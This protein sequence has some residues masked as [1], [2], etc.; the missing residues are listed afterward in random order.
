MFNNK[1]N[2]FKTKVKIISIIVVVFAIIILGLL[3]SMS[4][5]ASLT[6][7]LIQKDMQ[8]LNEEAKTLIAKFMGKV[9]LDTDETEEDVL[10]ELLD[11]KLSLKVKLFEG[12]NVF[13][14]EYIINDEELGNTYFTREDLK[15][16]LEATK[17]A[18][19][20]E[21]NTITYKVKRKV[22]ERLVVT[23]EY[24]PEETETLEDGTVVVVKPEVPEK[25]E[26]QAVSEDDESA[27]TY[28]KRT[29]GA[30]SAQYETKNISWKEVYSMYVLVSLAKSDGWEKDT[31]INKENDEEDEYILGNRLDKD[32]LD[33][34]IDMFVYDY[35][36]LYDAARTDKTDLDWDDLENVTYMYSEEKFETDT[37]RGTIYVKVPTSSIAFI[38]NSYYYYEVRTDKNRQII[39]YYE[40]FDA[41]KFFAT[42]YSKT[43]EFKWDWYI[44][45]LSQLPG[46]DDLCKKY[47]EYYESY[48][49]GEEFFKEYYSSNSNELPD[50]GVTIGSGV[51]NVDGDGNI[52]LPKPPDYI[53]DTD[54]L[55]A[56]L[57]LMRKDNLTQEQMEDV[58]NWWLTTA[59][60]YSS[61][62]MWYPEIKVTAKAFLDAQ[63]ANGISALGMLA[64]ASHESGFGTSQIA[65]DKY[66]FF[67]YGAFDASPYASALTC[68]GIYNGIVTIVTK[69]TNGY[70]KG[71]YK[72]DTFWKFRHNVVD[73][74]PV[75]QYCT[76]VWE[77][78]GVRCVTF[79]E[80]LMKYCDAKG[81]DLGYDVETG[82]NHTT[83]EQVQNLIST[84]AKLQVG[85]PYKYR[86]TRL[87]TGTDC[88][89][90]VKQI[91]QTFASATNA[92]A[93]VSAYAMVLPTSYKDQLLYGFD[94]GSL[95]DIQPADVIY[96]RS[97]GIIYRSAVYI[98]NNMV[99][100]PSSS[101]KKVVMEEVS[102]ES[103]NIY[104]IK[105][106]VSETKK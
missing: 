96:Y 93:D 102:I 4:G 57:T 105:R 71:P 12:K 65:R 19:K 28:P 3:D 106:F 13:K 37:E 94:V 39:G 36:Y 89:N 87:A 104:K 14:T 27:V 85:K 81:Y 54:G 61:S 20:V 49:R 5:T 43:N 69:I 24:Q 98:G 66:N 86:G 48:L 90:F 23:Q 15:T 64:L 99:V 25:K 72:Q 44:A 40:Q 59:H 92:H 74:V 100:Y 79:R 38:T 60:N 29:V 22:T 26:W 16:L 7:M 21:S 1:L 46:T 6:D 41:K 45:L 32:L 95:S 47:S 2:G 70:P 58:L 91:F 50:Y 34:I 42:A 35:D 82:E 67:G 10:L 52:V 53:F 17:K 55:G 84:Y 88:Q 73:G 8:E 56:D 103:G 97:K 31:F 77:V 68:D 11:L 62:S 83:L 76:D 63:E 101:A 18:K 78:W 80:E 30:N 33:Q 51:C 75:H 9:P